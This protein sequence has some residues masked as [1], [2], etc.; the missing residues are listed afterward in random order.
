[1]GSSQKISLHTLFERTA[2]AGIELQRQDGSFP[3]GNN[4]P[5]RD[6]TTPIRNTSNWLKIL[7]FVFSQT[8]DERFKIASNAAIEYLRQDDHR[9]HGYTYRCRTNKVKDS[10]NGVVGQANVIEAFGRAGNYL[11]RP[12]LYDYAAEIY[13]LHP[14]NKHTGVWNRVEIDGKV[15]SIDRTFNHQLIFAAASSILANQIGGGIELDIRTFLDNLNANMATHSSGI[16]IHRLRPYIDITSFK[17]IINDRS[18]ELFLNPILHMK[19]T[20]MSREERKMKEMGYHS[21]NLYWL[22]N[23]KKRMPNHKVWSSLPIDNLLNVTRR[24]QYRTLAR[25]RKGWFSNIPPGFQISQSLNILEDQPD[26]DEIREWVQMAID[27][28]Y[29]RSSDL[30]NDNCDDG[31]TFSGLLYQAID[32]SDIIIEI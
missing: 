13:H 23:L 8:G 20:V 31:E 5:Y 29:D 16:V 4:G 30:F 10:C 7:S 9:P 12:E 18:P 27:K 19:D 26:R 14:F 24:A 32:I 28:H 15:L 6:N 3:P 21:V 11:N 17:S 2:T 1:M 25:Q 22:S